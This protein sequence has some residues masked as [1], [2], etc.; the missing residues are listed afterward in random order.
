MK[1]IWAKI[2]RQSIQVFL[3]W[4]SLCG[5]SRQ[6]PVLYR[7]TK[8]LLNILNELII[9]LLTIKARLGYL[10]PVE[11]FSST[12]ETLWTCGTRDRA[13]TPGP[14]PVDKPLIDINKADN[15]EHR[16]FLKVVMTATQMNCCFCQ[17]PLLSF[18][19]C[20]R[21]LPAPWPSPLGSLSPPHS[22]PAP[23]APPGPTCGL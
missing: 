22:A 14:A 13:L 6:C 3:A 9:K 18:P 10:H 4:I 1:P 17:P 12:Q 20:P 7:S 15:N 19:H 2:K 11:T 5:E 23:P 16:G 8:G 21:V